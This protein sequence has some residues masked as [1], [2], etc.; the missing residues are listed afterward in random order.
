VLYRF[1]P[2]RQ[3]GDKHLLDEC[4]KWKR[5]CCEKTPPNHSLFQKNYTFWA[6]KNCGHAL[7][8]YTA[9]W[10]KKNCTDFQHCE[11]WAW[12]RRVQESHPPATTRQHIRRYATK[13]SQVAYQTY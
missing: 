5:I 7:D 12:V 8:A 2:A 1:C 4:Q 13:P 9:Q 10:R 11:A 3:H 6:R